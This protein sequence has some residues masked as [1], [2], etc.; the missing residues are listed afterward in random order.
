MADEQRKRRGWDRL[1]TI[2]LAVYVLVLMVAA[3]DELFDLGVF[4]P[5]LEKQI[6]AHLKE[7]R[8][9]DTSARQAAEKW[10]IE[11]GHQFAVRQLIAELKNPQTRD[12]VAEILAKI[13][14]E[15]DLE[16]QARNAVTRL[17]E[18]DP[19]VSAEAAW[20]LVEI[21]H[22]GIPAITKAMR[23]P[24]PDIRARLRQIIVQATARY[25]DSDPWGAEK[26]DAQVAETVA[27]LANPALANAAAKKLEAVAHFAKPRLVNAL[28]DPQLQPKADQVLAQVAKQKPGQKLAFWEEWYTKWWEDWYEKNKASLGFGSDREAWQ[29]WYR[30]NKDHL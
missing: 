13:C 23:H 14:S 8:S 26:T 22:F 21:G 17:A 25:F 16:A 10:L 27:Q 30:M 1:L 3:V 15:L 6:T 24:R 20:E 4:P 19:S 28:F 18:T 2:A 29:L 7:L 9:S 12:K 5:E 11:E